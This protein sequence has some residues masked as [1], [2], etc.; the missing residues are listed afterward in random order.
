M[1]D[2]KALLQPESLR[3][4]IVRGG[5]GHRLESL[6]DGVFA[7]AIAILLIATSVPKNFNDLLQFVY[8]AVPLFICM[9]FIYSIWHQQTVFFLRYGL[10]DKHTIRLNL[11]LLFLTLFYAYPLK[12]L[13]TWLLQFMYFFGG[14]LLGFEGFWQK[15]GELSQMISFNDMPLLMIIYGLGFLGIF[16]IF[17]LLYLHAFK[18][19]DLLEL[20]EV[21]IT[22]TRFSI[23][24]V[25]VVM[26]VAAVSVL[27]AFIGFLMDAPFS[28]FFAGLAY[29]LLWIISIPLSKKHEKQLQTLLT[30]EM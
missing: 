30:G 19:K 1:L 26:L 15:M 12:F 13:M 6:S 10:Y 29:N 23:I 11:V 22:L 27:I 3:H 2:R 20:N 7:L 17:Y 18:Q 24:Q 9:I 25:K 8:D 28:G 5:Q 21:E 16:F 4:F 14:W